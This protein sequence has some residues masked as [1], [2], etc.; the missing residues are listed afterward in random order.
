M[1]VCAFLHDDQRKK[2]KAPLREKLFLLLAFTA[3][4]QTRVGTTL[5]CHWCSGAP[6]WIKLWLDSSCDHSFPGFFPLPSPDCLAL[7]VFL[8]NKS[9]SGIAVWEP[10]LRYSNL[11]SSKSYEGRPPIKQRLKQ[12]GGSLLMGPWF[13]ESRHPGVETWIPKVVEFTWVVPSFHLMS[14]ESP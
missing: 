3:W 12:E 7:S 10:G 5:G 8:F 11:L 1:C 13:S 14:S 6:Q 2:E 4:P 9:V